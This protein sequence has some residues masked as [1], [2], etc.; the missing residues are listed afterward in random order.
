M[1]DGA[2]G[3]ALENAHV[4]TGM[5]ISFV[6]TDV[7]RCADDVHGPKKGPP[8]LPPPRLPDVVV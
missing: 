2:L 1:K 5:N 6:D 4:H 7:R 3:R 8:R